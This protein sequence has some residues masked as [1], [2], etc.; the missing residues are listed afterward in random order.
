MHATQVAEWSAGDLIDFPT[1]H[2][3]TVDF[4]EGGEVYYRSWR[5]PVPSPNSF[6]SAQRMSITEFSAAV[7]ERSGTARAKVQEDGAKESQDAL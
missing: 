7:L 1:G 4:V 3:I 2:L 6:I 5:A